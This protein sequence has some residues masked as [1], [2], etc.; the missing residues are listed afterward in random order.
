MCQW[1]N[2]ERTRDLMLIAELQHK[3]DEY[4]RER[5]ELE[6]KI[7]LEMAADGAVVATRKGVGRLPPHGIRAPPAPFEL[8]PEEDGGGEK[9]GGGGGGGGGGEQP[10]W[11]G[12]WG[13]ESGD[14]AGDGGW[15]G[16]EGFEEGPAELVHG[17]GCAQVSAS[18]SVTPAA[19]EEDEEEENLSPVEL[20][21][22]VRKDPR[23][24]PHQ[25]PRSRATARS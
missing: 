12:A 20:L 21:E 18:Q 17:E 13:G 19:G 2:G 14:L 8:P 4:E 5:G 1:G 10:C 24:R 15:T 3:V 25:P 9:R 16:F 22:R 11:C 7:R 23:F 6:D